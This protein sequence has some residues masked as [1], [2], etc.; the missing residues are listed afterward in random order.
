MSLEHKNEASGLT[1]SIDS[2]PSSNEQHGQ[3]SQHYAD[4]ALRAWSTVVGAFLLQFYTVGVVCVFI[5][6]YI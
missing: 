4:G 1:S 6:L 2:Q 5:Y 3:Q